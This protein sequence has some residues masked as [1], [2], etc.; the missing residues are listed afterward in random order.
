MTIKHLYTKVRTAFRFYFLHFYSLN[1]RLLQ[2]L[3][4]KNRAVTLR[5]QNQ[6]GIDSVKSG[7]ST[8]SLTISVGNAYLITLNGLPLPVLNDKHT[9]TVN[10]P[11]EKG[12]NT[13]TVC[14]KGIGNK[15]QRA[16]VVE[17]HQPAIHHFSFEKRLA[18]KQPN[19]IASALNRRLKEPVIQKTTAPLIKLKPLTFKR[20]SFILTQSLEKDFSN[21]LANNQKQHE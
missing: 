21:F 9:V 17:N 19:R 12:E 7:G 5:V 2:L 11:L 18:V 8:V 13:L 20:T 3:F 10:W 1:K 6:S 14:A 15:K 16:F 4:R